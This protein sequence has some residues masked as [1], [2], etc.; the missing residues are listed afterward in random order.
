M[1]VKQVQFSEGV[2]VHA[3][4]LPTPRGDVCLKGVSDLQPAGCVCACFL[5]DDFL[6]Q[7]VFEGQT[8]AKSSFSCEAQIKQLTDTGEQRGF[9]ELPVNTFEHA[10]SISSRGV[11]ENRTAKGF[12]VYAD[13]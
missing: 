5:W 7:I 6:G 10:S 1:T 8:H 4:G 11:G 9:N 3:S 2:F 13:A 12:C